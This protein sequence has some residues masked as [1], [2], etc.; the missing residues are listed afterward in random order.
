V[1]YGQSLK[2]GDLLVAAVSDRSSRKSRAHASDTVCTAPRNH[3]VIG[4]LAQLSIDDA[5]GV[6]RVFIIAI[7]P[8]CPKH[9]PKSAAFFTAIAE[10]SRLT[11]E[12]RIQAL[13]GAATLT[14][15]GHHKVRQD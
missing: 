2:S 10:I 4:S 5:C 15:Y 9:S 11:A 14:V 3:H 12:Q 1:C 13:R 6:T 8:A 7:T